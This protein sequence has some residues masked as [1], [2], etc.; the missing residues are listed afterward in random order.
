MFRTIEDQIKY[1]K[2]KPPHFVGPIGSQHMA[3]ILRSLH[4]DPMGRILDF[5]CGIGRIHNGLKLFDSKPFDYY[6]GL[7]ISPHYLSIFRKSNPNVCLVL[8][9][10]LKIPLLANDFDT[11]ICYSVFTH[12]YPKHMDDILKEFNR[13][14]KPKG[15]A[16]ISIFEREVVGVEEIHNWVTIERQTFLDLCEKHKFKV[17][18]ERNVPS[19]EYVYQTLFMLENIG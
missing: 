19:R 7:D 11:I 1:W 16:L 13:V 17:I 18:G 15:R 2:D 3:E 8:V 9:K 6:V 10:D 5:G 4:P 14:I 12:M